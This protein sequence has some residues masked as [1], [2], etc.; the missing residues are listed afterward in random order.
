MRYFFSLLLA[1]A[2]IAPALAQYDQSIQVEGK[3]TPEYINHDRIGVFPKPVRF[4]MEK[5]KLDYSLQ[6]VNADFTPNAV[7]IQ[8]TGWQ[9]TRTSADSRGYV[10]LGLGSWLESTL[11]AGYRII[12]N[13]NSALGVRFQHNSTSL[14]QPKLSDY[15]DT[16][17]WRYDESIGVYGHHTFGDKGRLDAAIDY[18]LGNFN[19][20]GFDPAIYLNGVT[21]YDQNLNA[22]TQTLNDVS[23]RLAWH[24]PYAV[25]NIRWNVGAGVRYFGYRSY[26]CPVWIDNL[27]TMTGGRETD[28]NVT[29][30]FAFPTSSKSSL[31]IDLNFDYLHY[32]EPKW[33]T[34]PAP[35]FSAVPS[36]DSYGMVSL[37]PYYRF[38]KSRLNIQ[39]GAKIDLAFNAG[40]ENDHYGAFHIAPSIRLDYDAGPMTL[41]L[42]A[43]GGS[44]LHTLAANYERDYY[45]APGLQ[46]TTPVYTPLDADL[47]VAFG[48]FAGF[49]VGFDIAFRASRGQYFGGF[50][51]PY[52]NEVN[53]YIAL[54]LPETM[55][56]RPV[57]YVL[58][59]GA[60]SNLNG[61]SFGLNMG[62]DSGRYFKL[63]AEGRYQ[64]QNGKAGYFNGYDRPEVTAAVAVET[65]PWSTLKFKLAYDLRAMRMMPVQ[66]HYAD[67]T[68]LNSDLIGMY[69]LPNLSMLNLGASYGILDNLNVWIQADNLLCRKQYYMPG[70]PEPGIRLAAGIGFT[71]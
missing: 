51:L 30:G 16:R 50:Y 60:K 22:P 41:F 47:G 58:T 44:S 14:W 38:V 32:A 29:A 59:P 2:C 27:I 53:P 24:S 23:A 10:E 69:R 66:A 39:L 43:L 26:Y 33:K 3:Y 18:H 20:Y 67:T 35:D 55:D 52:L 65:N 28:V 40:P 6:G 56:N 8:A 63:T 19:Y 5:S 42:H 45:Q 71:F 64:H 11:S 7:P 4:A 61:F 70:L 49:H 62:Y 13:R 34:D 21:G 68:P 25:D 12:D 48:P 15:L 36:L 46:S 17:Q 37:T 9:T 31:G 57:N 54:G 1:S